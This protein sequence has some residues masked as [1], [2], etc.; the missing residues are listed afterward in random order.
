V[1]GLTYL[2]RYVKPLWPWFLL[3]LVGSLAFAGGTVMLLPV[4]K[5]I[6]GE[7]LAPAVELDKVSGNL[8]SELIATLIPSEA[9]G[10]QERT[11]V[12]HYIFGIYNWLKKLF[13][14]DRSHAVYFIPSLFF[15]VFLIRSL[16]DFLSAYSFQRIGYGATYRIRIDLFQK[17]VD[18]SSRFYGRHPSDELVSRLIH[19]VGVLQAAI[20]TRLVDLFQQSITLIALLLTLFSMSWQLSLISLLLAPAVLYPIARFSRSMRRLSHRAQERT[21]DL[22]SLVGEVARGHRIV[23]AFGM[24]RFELERFRQASERHLRANLKGQLIASLSSPVVETIGVAGF[25]GFLVFAGKAV[26]SGSLQA[27]SLMLFLGN[28]YMLYDPLRKLNRANVVIQ[29]SLAAA[30]R[31]FHLESEPIE[32][33]DRPGAVVLSRFSSIIRFEGVCFRYDHRVVLDGVNLEL[34]RGQ[35]VALV[36]ASGSGKTT[37]SNLLLRYFDP[38]AGRITI[39]G[40]DLRDCTIASLRQQIALVTQEPLLFND[41]IRN[42]LAYGRADVPFEDIRRAAR[43]AY[44]EEFIEALPQGYETVVGEGGFRLSGGQRQRLAIARA[45]LKNAP[46]LILDEA[47]SQLDAAS[48]KEVQQ[49]LANLMEDRT[50]LVIAHRLVTVSRADMI[51][52]LENGRIVESGSH[53]ELLKR[54]GSYWKLYEAQL[55]EEE[56]Q[57][58]TRR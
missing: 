30:Q 33:Q 17:I 36:G 57:L 23:K 11:F 26:S 6:F 31:L 58:A 18:Q 2:F 5:A 28:L 14:I 7:L 25:A 46:I 53:E 41:T 48:E 9:T 15:A 19:D 35:V 52:V 43:A 22:A 56:A 54:R 24:E 55:G 37:L 1:P 12:L 29:Q 38:T 4:I 34:R 20:S 21:A 16:G 40:I 32:I 47:T 39:D 45:L 13:G 8:P 49:A 42:N 3:S 27:D 51:H 44:A 10:G 50:V